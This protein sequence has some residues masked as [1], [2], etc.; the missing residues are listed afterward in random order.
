MTLQ[1]LGEALTRGFPYWVLAASG[2]ALFVPSAFT[3]FSGSLIT[4]GL[5]VVMLGMG[6]TL[7]VDDFKAVAKMPRAVLAGVLAQFLI[8]PLVGYAAAHVT[9]LPVAFAVGVILVG[10]CPGGTASNVVTY[11]AGGHVALSVLMTMCSTF[12]AIIATPLLTQALA[13]Q[14]VPIVAWDLFMSTVQVVLLPLVLGL[15]LHHVAPR[16]TRALLPVS[17]LVSVLVIALICASIVGSSGHALMSSGLRLLAA[18]FVLHAGG[19][20]FG[21]G[22]ARAL[23]FDTQVARTISIEVGMQNSGLGAVLARRHFAD[24]LTAVPCAISATMHSLI[25]SLLAGIWRARSAPRS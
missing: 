20:A 4:F 2:T 8:M 11:L 16:L 1:R 13:G 19:F 15:V 14:L 23:G 5:A 21:Y 10:C 22:F 12:F 7:S 24:P 9:G 6:L 17:P 25:G 3:W 18:V